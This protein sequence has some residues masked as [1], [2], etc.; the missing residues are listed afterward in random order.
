MGGPTRQTAYRD[1]PGRRFDT[2]EQRPSSPQSAESPWVGA[3]GR[4]DF[5]HLDWCMASGAGGTT[6]PHATRPE[7][8]ERVTL[9]VTEAAGP[10]P[11]RRASTPSWAG[12]E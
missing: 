8:D 1:N 4:L 7:R 9:S 6:G 5:V 2:A 3:R 12:A 10:P 11:N